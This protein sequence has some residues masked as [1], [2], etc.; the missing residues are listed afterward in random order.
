MGD[1]IAWTAYAL[2][3]DWEPRVSGRTVEV[4][5][6]Y[7][8]IEGE[9]SKASVKKSDL[10]QVKDGELA[11]KEPGTLGYNEETNVS[12]VNIDIRTVDRNRD[13]FSDS[14]RGPGAT[15]LFGKRD[16]RTNTSER[17]GGLVGEATRILQEYRRG[18]N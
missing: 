11:T 1:P 7:I 6:P 14:L 2:E 13:K 15:R 17:Y 8:S 16:E 12:F 9:D 5:Q 4:P 18:V 10:I 3:E